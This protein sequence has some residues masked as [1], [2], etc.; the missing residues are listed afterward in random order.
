MFVGQLESISLTGV[1]YST[2][3]IHFRGGFEGIMID[4]GATRRNT[5]GK[6]Q[7]L[8]YCHATGRKVDI[9]SSRA[10]VCHFVIFS[11]ALIGVAQMVFPLGT[12]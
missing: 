11:S 8:T 10:T 5:S 9:D 7:Y 4:T 1:I 12:L 6:A 2:I 3:L